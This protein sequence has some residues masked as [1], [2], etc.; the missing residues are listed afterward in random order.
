MIRSRMFAKNA[1]NE[2]TEVKVGTDG[3]FSFDIDT[4]GLATD[5]KLDTLITDLGSVATDAKLDTVITALGTL[6]TSIGDLETALTA[7]SA[8]LPTALTAGGNLKVEESGTP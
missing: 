8:Q 4:T 5:A 1:G 2:L 6:N 3:A 7:L